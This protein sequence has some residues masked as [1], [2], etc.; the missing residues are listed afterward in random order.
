LK[1]IFFEV[2][3]GE[4]VGII[5]RDGTGKSTLLKNPGLTSSMPVMS[6]TR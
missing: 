6:T 5:G 2:K 4:V 3:Q 1:D